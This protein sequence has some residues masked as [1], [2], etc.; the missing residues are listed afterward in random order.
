MADEPTLPILSSNLAFDPIRDD[1]SR[2]RVRLDS[3][4]TTQISSD[5]PLFSSDDDPSAE[6]YSGLRRHQKKKFRGPWFK[7]ELE[8]GTSRDGVKTSKR[9]FQRQFDSA[10]WLGS[11]GTDVEDE[12]IFPEAGLP[13]STP[14]NILSLP[15]RQSPVRL[16]ASQ[17]SKEHSSPEEL[18]QK[19]IELCLEVGKEDIDL[20]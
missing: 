13:P 5:P 18:A 19:Q 16:R 11:D 10:V 3:D 6:N 20:S 1:A 9:T 14:A 17:T 12:S 15:M 8:L 4:N 2:K 7:Q